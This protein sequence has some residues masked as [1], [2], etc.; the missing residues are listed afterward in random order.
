MSKFFNK[1]K[2]FDEIIIKFCEECLDNKT[3][4]LKKV[5]IE[6]KFGEKIG[7]EI[8]LF[9]TQKGGICDDYE[10][11]TC[12]NRE[13]LIEIR[14]D[15]KNR[16]IIA[17]QVF[18]TW[19]NLCLLATSIIISLG[20]LFITNA[21]LNDNRQLSIKQIELIEKQL[22]SISSLN[23]TLEI[24]LDFP[25]DRIIHG[26]DFAWAYN[27][28][29]DYEKPQRQTARI[30]FIVYNFG[31]MNSGPINAFL[32]NPV[33]DSMRGEHQ[34]G[35]L[36]LDGESSGRLEFE[37]WY[38]KCNL[39]IEKEQLEN[40]TVYERRF[41]LPECDYRKNESIL[42]WHLFNLTLK[43]DFCQEKEKTFVEPFCI[44]NFGDELNAVCK[45]MPEHIDS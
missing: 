27:S 20:T 29:N 37:V 21:S 22:V 41:F 30:Q 24:G 44:T 2:R 36:Y 42:G 17:N 16:L 32:T 9:L 31:R 8:W 34:E 6:T 14:E 4:L 10:N 39:Q 33:I 13:R 3:K 12:A 15:A 45:Q 35:P 5:E 43:C 28:R 23:A 18:L 38:N 7:N 11:N 40:G 25:D 19:L 26:D 1:F